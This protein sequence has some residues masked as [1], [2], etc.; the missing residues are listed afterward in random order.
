MT[1]ASPR[2]RCQSNRSRT[3]GRTCRARCRWAKSA[4]TSSTRSSRPRPGPARTGAPWPV[5]GRPAGQRGV[6]RSGG[7]GPPMRPA[8]RAVRR[9]RQ[10]KPNTLP[11]SVRVPSKSKAATS[12]IGVVSSAVSARRG[13]PA[14]PAA[15]RRRRT[16]A[17]PDTA[18]GEARLSRPQRVS[19]RRASSRGSPHLGQR[20]QP[21]VAHAGLGQCGQLL[22]PGHRLGEG[23]A[24]R[25]HSVDQAHGQR[26]VGPDRPTGQDEVEGPA[27]RR[28]AGAGGP[29][30]RR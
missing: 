27:L 26:L 2:R 8:P 16:R 20:R 9:P 3:S 7:R 12:G 5:G 24:R 29:S 23:G 22:G 18:S 13:R 1:T 15:R 19:A 30:R 17:A 14:T 6:A 28:P 10:R 11:P 25:H 4:A 21:V